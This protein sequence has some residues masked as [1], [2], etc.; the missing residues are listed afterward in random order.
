MLQ[1]KHI[2]KIRRDRKNGKKRRNIKDARGGDALRGGQICG[3]YS[4]ILQPISV[5]A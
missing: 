5:K 2:D 1:Q 4:L 3:C